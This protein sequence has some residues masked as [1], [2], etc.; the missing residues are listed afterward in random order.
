MSKNSYPAL[1][2]DKLQGMF[3]LNPELTLFTRDFTDYI[4]NNDIGFIVYDRN[5]LD[6]NMLNS[7]LLQL[8]YSNDRYVIFKIIK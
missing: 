3:I 7:K 6:T 1:Q 4:K 5:H 8:I 2:P